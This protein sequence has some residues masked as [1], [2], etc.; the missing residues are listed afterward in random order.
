[1]PSLPPKGFFLIV[2][3]NPAKRPCFKAA[4]MPGKYRTSSVILF[5]NAAYNGT[6]PE[7]RAV[8]CGT[9]HSTV[10]TSAAMDTLF[11]RVLESDPPC[12]HTSAIAL[13][14]NG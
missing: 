2:D 4:E 6:R 11:T 7:F 3:R 14:T 10:S 5:Y 12:Q 1:M 9:L 8:L 13:M